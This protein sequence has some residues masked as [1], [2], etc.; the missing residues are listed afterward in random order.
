[1]NTTDRDASLNKLSTSA[2]DM[3][4]TDG[5]PSSCDSRAASWSSSSLAATD[6]RRRLPLRALGVFLGLGVGF[7][8]I[9][10]VM[11]LRPILCVCASGG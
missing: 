7:L 3:G 6:G 2:H 1:M 9:F 11:Q 5:G 10:C 4:G 8:A